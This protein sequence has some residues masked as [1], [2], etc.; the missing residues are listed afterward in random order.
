MKLY[1]EE[2]KENA[3]QKEE[4]EKIKAEKERLEAVE[5]ARKAEFLPNMKELIKSDKP[6][7]EVILRL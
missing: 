3:K 6:E 2:K 5:V 7:F 1:E 4:E